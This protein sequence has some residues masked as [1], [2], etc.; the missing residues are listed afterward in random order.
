MTYISM[1]PKAFICEENCEGAKQPSGGRVWEGGV[2]PPGG[3]GHSDIL[4]YICVSKKK[5]VKR[6][7]FSCGTRNAR[8]VVRGPKTLI[9]NKKG[10]FYL[11]RPNALGGKFL[12]RRQCV[13]GTFSRSGA[14]APGRA[15][16][17]VSS[18]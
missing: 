16:A 5:R 9:F 18:I 2:S 7:L 17:G 6:G 3:G 4:V 8:S 14:R 15:D 10:C 12:Y 1:S 13:D 11:I